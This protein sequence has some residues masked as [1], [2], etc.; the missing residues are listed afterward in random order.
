[1]GELTEAMAGGGRLAG[2]HGAAAVHQEQD[3]VR[4]NPGRL[5]ELVQP[6]Q[7][8]KGV[9]HPAHGVAWAE[10]GRAEGEGR[11]RRD[12]PLLESAGGEGARLHDAVNR[13]R[14]RPRHGQAA[15]EALA[16]GERTPRSA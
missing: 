8:E 6:A 15:A 4:G 3:G 16:G 5:R 7:I 14:G 13:T 10:D 11:T 9:H 1:M 12:A 2:Q